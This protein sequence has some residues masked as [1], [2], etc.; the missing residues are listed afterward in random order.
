MGG[1]PL[2]SEIQGFSVVSWVCLLSVLA[3]SVYP[4]LKKTFQKYAFPISFTASLLLFTLI[5]WYCGFCKFPVQIAIITF[6]ILLF[7]HILH[8]N[9]TFSDLKEQWHWGLIFFIFFFLDWSDCPLG[10]NISI[11]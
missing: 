9:L 6:L 2:I 5:S 7:Y 1:V 3:L 4:S 8:R 11:I 10:L